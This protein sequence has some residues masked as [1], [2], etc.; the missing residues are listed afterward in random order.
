M[1]ED[2]ARAELGAQVQRA[3]GTIIVAYEAPELSVGSVLPC[4][5]YYGVVFEQPSVVLRV[6]TYSEWIARCG[7]VD[8]KGQVTPDWHFYEIGFD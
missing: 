6:A 7:W 4:W 3:G 1:T 5:D 2:E 8:T